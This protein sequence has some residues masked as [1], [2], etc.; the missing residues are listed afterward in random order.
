[1]RKPINLSGLIRMLILVINFVVFGK[2][3]FAH[4]LGV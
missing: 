2:H 1:M 4:Y 3:I